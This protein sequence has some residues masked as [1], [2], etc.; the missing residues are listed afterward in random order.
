M[1]KLSV[2]R[3]KNDKLY[4]VLFQILSAVTGIGIG[5]VLATFFPPEIYGLYNLQFATV[6]LFTSIFIAPL[7][8]F[9]K[10]HNNT[11]NKKIGTNIYNKILLFLTFLSFCFILISFN[12]LDFNISEILFCTIF[13]YIIFDAI[14]KIKLNL[15]QTSNYL[16]TYGLLEALQKIFY[17]IALF[18]CI[19]TSKINSFEKI[20]YAITIS[21]IISFFIS[22]YKIK[23]ISKSI[24]KVST[25]SLI[26]RL[27]VF[28]KPLII[29]GIFAW[30]TNYFDRYII[31][32]FMSKEDVGIYNASYSLGSKFFLLLSPIF[33]T[34][35]TPLI[36]KNEKL[37]IKK[38]EINKY[39]N[40]YLIISF[41]SI[42]LIFLFYPI[43]GKVFL[44]KSYS[45]GFYI[46][47]GINLAY[48]LLTL[49]Y[50]YELLF[51]AES[52]TKYIL[53]L[54]F[55]SA[56]FNI[57]LNVILVNKYGITGAMIS[58]IFSFLIRFLIAK[59]LYDK[60]KT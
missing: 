28:S 25:Y 59:L 57:I 5:K 48:F 41:F 31:D 7:I 37:N 21:L 51:Y 47:A 36:Y 24:F 10:T 1:S 26:K 3:K 34:I 46:I 56:I 8:Q 40:V 20:W 6:L 16:I 27:Y 9:I 2:L 32:F 52:L 11:L 55:L 17:L 14:F 4:L 35:L 38:T 53:Y 12:F 54:N 42:I 39:I 50:F 23:S 19:Y 44:S 22:N 33:I 60:L 58:T 49:S 45:D 43:I 18:V 29:M 13:L 15:A 30:L